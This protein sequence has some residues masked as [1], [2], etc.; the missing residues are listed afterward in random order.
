MDSPPRVHTEQ[1]SPPTEMEGGSGEHTPT[2][3]IVTYKQRGFGKLHKDQ[4]LSG[5]V[6]SLA[7]SWW[8][9]SSRPSNRPWHN[10]PRRRKTVPPDQEVAYERTKAAMKKV[11]AAFSNNA[12]DVAIEVLRFAADV[13]EVAPVVGLA[14]AARVLHSI[15][16]GVQF[17]ETNRLSCLRLTERCATILY[18]VCSE[19]SAAGQDVTDILLEPVARLIESFHKIEHF[20]QKQVS[21]PFLKRYLKRDEDAWKIM[22]CNTSL[23]DSV[24]LF[25]VAIQ[26]RMLKEVREQSYHL[27][28]PGVPAR[29]VPHEIVQAIASIRAAQAAYDTANDVADLYAAMRAALRMGSD[30]AMLEVL[31]INRGEMQEAIKTLQRALEDP[32]LSPG[33]VSQQQSLPEIESQAV[34]FIVEPD[35]PS[36]SSDGS[37]SS[38]ILAQRWGTNPLAP[39]AW[40][41]DQDA[42]FH[43]EF[44]ESGLDAL[45]RL[46][47]TSGGESL[48]PWTITRW[49][50]DRE[51]KIGMGFFSDVFKGTWQGRQ[52]AIKILAPTTPRNL[53]RHETSIWASLKH[54]YVLEL[55]GASSATGDPPWFF[56]SPYM[57]NGTL[58]SFL[59]TVRATGEVGRGRLRMYPGP[60]QMMYEIAVGMAYL[61]RKGVLHGDLKANNVLIDDDLHCVI[62]DFGQSELRSEVYRLSHR[63]QPHGTLRWQAPEILSGESTLTSEADVYAF[64]VVCVEILT[65]GE[66]PWP[67]LDDQAVQQLVLYNNKRPKIPLR[68][69]T[70]L[71]LVAL[72]ESCWSTDPLA[73]PSFDSVARGLGYLG[74]G[75]ARSK[76]PSPHRRVLDL[77][78]QGE[79]RP[80]PDMAP[81]E[82]PDVSTQE[83]LA[84]AWTTVD[85]PVPR[86]DVESDFAPLSPANIPLQRVVTPTS[87]GST[88]VSVAFEKPQEHDDKTEHLIPRPMSPAS[89]IFTDIQ[90][91]SPE[92][93]YHDVWDGYESPPPK[94]AHI[95]AMRDER[96]YRLLLQHDFHPTL[97]LPLWEP[98]PVSLGAIGYLSKPRG[99][100]VTLF[101]A[102]N[103]SGAPDSR[104]HGMPSI[105]GYGVVREAT[106]RQ[107]RRNIAQIGI[108]MIQG[109]LTFRKGSAGVVHF[110]ERSVKKRYSFPLRAGHKHAYLCTENTTYR[111]MVDTD[112]AKAWFKS[113]VEKI[114]LLYG[115]E[116]TIQREDV[117]LVIG[118][119][120]TRDYGLFV[121]HEHPDGQVH[122][123]IFMDRRVGQDWGTFS[124]DSDV[125]S[126][127]PGPEFNLEGDAPKVPPVRA[128]KI[129]RVHAGADGDAVLLAR[130]RFKPDEDE[131]TRL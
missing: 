83:G 120:E 91:G 30:I 45:R 74:G 67:M 43:R 42:A 31:Q 7:G 54:T 105:Y 89:S 21:R 41:Q 88:V 80:S 11:A 129:S 26:L 20:V 18:S 28:H 126:T 108:D 22:A 37:H 81:V 102:L 78:R 82:L 99:N 95:A 50:V 15:W 69:E 98:S 19:I 106:S 70:S 40:N 72:I 61:H 124:T 58:V 55:L 47:G 12:T 97:N 112:A 14:E 121:S 16:Q 27:D 123:N 1:L 96:R 87:D 103:P 46:S 57:K 75:L 39:A 60:L 3:D 122:F 64:A 68:P 118:T 125:S 32:R 90:E 38:R 71:S 49:E 52:V 48:P 128:T 92:A 13:L 131:P 59:K 86:R 23:T 25:S 127:M 53:F 73:R 113:N 51:G 117:F 5:G 93:D 24:A 107:D 6:I 10:S 130:L 34:S 114:V 8:G 119:L 115:K 44:L 94:D 101:N 9:V 85:P 36:T 104:V 62:S 79:R 56:V 2:T 77:I 65:Y 63:P 4:V 110:R 66:L 111:Y 109:L 35:T 17:V 76:S 84:D 100:F 116:H 29:P 33:R